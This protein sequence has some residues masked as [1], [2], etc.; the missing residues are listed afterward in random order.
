VPFHVT[1]SLY[2][3][4]KRRAIGLSAGRNGSGAGKLK[5]KRMQVF[6]EEQDGITRVVLDGRMDIEGAGAIDLKMNIIGGTK[7]A[8]LVDMQKVSY[9]ASIGIGVLV[10]VAK[11]M[12]MRGG[13]FVFFA[14]CPPV[15]KVLRNTGIYRVIPVHYELEPAIAALK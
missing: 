10:T 9:L 3:A 7:T 13:K 6:T 12:Q 4:C 5:G 11:A 14:P 1:L 15:D 8:V 2:V